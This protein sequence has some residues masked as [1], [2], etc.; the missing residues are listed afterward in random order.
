MHRD[1]LTFPAHCTFWVNTIISSLKILCSYLSSSSS[2][3]F[4]C[5]L[6]AYN[7]S[8]LSAQ[9]LSVVL[10]KHSHLL[11]IKHHKLIRNEAHS[12]HHCRSCKLGGRARYH[13]S[14][15][16]PATMWCK[17]HFL[18]ACRAQADNYKQACIK[19]ML[20]LAP[21]LGCSNNNVT[22]LCTNM[23]FGNGVRD[24][25]NESCPK[26]TDTSGIIAAGNSYCSSRST[27]RIVLDFD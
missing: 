1:Y 14:V 17:S 22:C 21:S 24:C 13:Q 15:G 12:P 10:T 9:H 20:G 6:R 8:T 16:Q 23:D 2:S 18:K 3:P 7:S 27:H 11:Q 5:I 4:T 26:G 25:S 19:S